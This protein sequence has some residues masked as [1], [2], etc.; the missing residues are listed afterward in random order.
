MLTGFPQVPTQDPTQDPMQPPF[1]ELA[2]EGSPEPAS[3][4]GLII[5]ERA[6]APALIPNTPEHEALVR[7]VRNRI[8][9]SSSRWRDTQKSKWEEA[10]RN[11]R[12]LVSAQAGGTAASPW[13]RSIVVPYTY[14]VLQTLATYAV[15]TFT[16]RRPIAQIEGRGPE[17]V[18][19]AKL[20]EVV[21]D[22]QLEESATLLFLSW[23]MDALKY[24]A[25]ITKTIWNSW[26]GHYEGNLFIS[27]DPYSFYPDPRVSLGR[28]Q[29]GEFVGQEVWRGYTQVLNA[30]KKFGGPY[31]NVEKIPKSYVPPQVAPRSW[32]LGEFVHETADELDKG[33]VKLTELWAKIV[34]FDLKVGPGRK[35]EMWVITLANDTIIVRAE[36]S[37]YPHQQFPYQAIE[38]NYD[39]HVLGNPGVAQ[40]LEGLQQHLSWLFNSRRENVRRVLNGIFIANPALIHMDDLLRPQPGLIARLRPEAAALVGPGA[41]DAAIKQLDIRDVTRGHYGDMNSVMDLMKRIGATPDVLQGMPMEQ[42]RTTLGEVNTVAQQ[43]ASRSRMITQGFGAMGVRP[44]LRQAVSNNIHLLSQ[45]RYYRIVGEWP[46]TLQGS[47]QMPGSVRVGPADLLG[48]FDFPIMEGSIP[49][50]RAQLARTWFNIFELVGRIP[51]LQQQ[52]DLV[53]IFRHFAQQAG[54]KNIDQFLTPPV[55]AMPDEQISAMLQAGNLR[56]P[57]EDEYGTGGNGRRSSISGIPTG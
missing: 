17:D 37:A 51:Q 57:E 27:V 30:S 46:K 47:K 42:G 19:A 3:A 8:D 7:F 52:F 14:V 48:S 56:P 22:Y 23:F 10:D 24:G 1:L 12:A 53:A 5:V 33:F 29:D 16:Q 35:P 2:P 31:V 26:D 40:M 15:A 41:M 13:A 43:A 18:R 11:Y 9:F 44:M 6:P 54:V 20:H 45:E 49:T 50:D 34:P 39:P 36:Q 25:G 32:L 55:Q 21:L 4:E 28:L 38:S